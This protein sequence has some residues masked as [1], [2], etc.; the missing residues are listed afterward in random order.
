[1]AQND[2]LLTMQRTVHLAARDFSFGQGGLFVGAHVGRWRTTP[3]VLL[4]LLTA[5]IGTNLKVTSR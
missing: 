1:M 5:K 3:H 4:Q 2:K